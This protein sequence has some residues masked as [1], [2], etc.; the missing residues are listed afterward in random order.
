M[1][2]CS[3]VGCDHKPVGVVEEII[4]AGNFDNPEATIPGLRMAWCDEHEASL[5]PHALGKRHR[6]L[7]KQELQV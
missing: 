4:D 1:A 5:A 6:K 3:M 7:T 2:K